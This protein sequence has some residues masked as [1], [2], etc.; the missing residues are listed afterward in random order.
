MVLNN[1]WDVV[2]VMNMTVIHAL[3]FISVKHFNKF[4]DA[5]FA[6]YGRE[7]EEDENGQGY[8]RRL[9]MLA[10]KLFSAVKAHNKSADL[11]S[12]NFVVIGIVYGSLLGFLGKPASCS[13]YYIVV[14]YIGVVVQNLKSVESARR[15]IGSHL[16]VGCPPKVVV[17]LA[18]KLFSV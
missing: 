14:N 7:V 8:A 18:K 4:L 12:Y 15:K 1:P 5:L 2:A 3:N 6:A 16:F 13:A 11:A 17:A 9:K 10:L